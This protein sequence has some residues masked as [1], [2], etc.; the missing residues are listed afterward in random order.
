[1]EKPKNSRIRYT[2][3]NKYEKKYRKRIDKIC[4]K[5]EGEMEEKIKYD[6]KG[7]VPFKKIEKENGKIIYA[8]SRKR[9]GGGVGY[10]LTYDQIPDAYTRMICY[11]CQS[12]TEEFTL[13]YL[14]EQYFTNAGV[15][16]NKMDNTNIRWLIYGLAVA[17]VLIL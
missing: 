3:L 6:F 16:V 1:M 17:T 11:R 10:A 7:K 12:C 14:T 2:L 15:D 13:R 5:C 4:P 8:V 9:K